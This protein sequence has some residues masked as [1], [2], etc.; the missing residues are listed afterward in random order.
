MVD[1]GVNFSHNLYL[2]GVTNAQPATI[3]TSRGSPTPNQP[4]SAPRG[5]T[6]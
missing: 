4:Q 1:F 2:A 3:C 5:G 6:R